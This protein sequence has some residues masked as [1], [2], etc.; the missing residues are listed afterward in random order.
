M[1]AFAGATEPPPDLVKRV[2]ENERENESAR[3]HYTYRQSVVINEVD[4]KGGRFRDV[5]EVIFLPSGER[6][7]RAIGRAF[8]NLS[9][10][11]L[12]PEDFEDIRNIQPLMFTP[13]M[14]PRYQVRFRGEERVDGVDCWV[15]EI[16]PRQIFATFRMFEGMAW[17]ERNL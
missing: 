13:E 14:L 16:V 3:L 15:L 7:E 11:L 1:L 5:R 6:T 9:R 10:L 2:S 8:N 12:T 4:P 17:V